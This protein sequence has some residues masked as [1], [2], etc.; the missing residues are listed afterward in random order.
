MKKKFNYENTMKKLREKGGCFNCG[1]KN[2]EHLKSEVAGNEDP[3][4]LNVFAVC[5]KCKRGFVERYRVISVT[6][7]GKEGYVKE[8]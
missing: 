7:L 3:G 2:Y 1:S 4:V 5:H 6:D 8:L